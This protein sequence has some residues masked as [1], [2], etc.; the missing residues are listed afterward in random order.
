[1]I[2]G[3][4][5]IE[6]LIVAAGKSRRTGQLYKMSLDFGGQTL[7]EKSI[8]SMAPFCSRI[9]IVTGYNSE[10]IEVILK[11][12]DNLKI[13]FNSH[14]EEGMFSSI[15]TGLEEISADR[16]FFLPGDCPLIPVQVYQ[17]MLEIDAEIVVPTFNNHN[18]HPVLFNRSVIEKILRGSFANLR[19]FISRHSP[20]QVE[21]G[22][23]GILVDIDTLAD[24]Q[25]A[26]TLVQD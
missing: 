10:K 8:A 1:M 13:V 20:A 17:K 12:Y 22:S 16:F 18:G 3:V 2:K 21:V 4:S 5:T 23:E 7:I 6:G 11:K 26:L 14:Y 24:Y 15:K 19:D 25:K 9:V